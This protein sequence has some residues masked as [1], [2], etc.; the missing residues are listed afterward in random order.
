MEEQLGVV[1]TGCWMTTWQQL[2]AFRN[3]YCVTHILTI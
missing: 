3:V 1:A 2:M